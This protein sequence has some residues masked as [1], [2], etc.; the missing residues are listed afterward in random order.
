[1]AK[2]KPAPVPVAGSIVPVVIFGVEVVF[3]ADWPS[4]LQG[5]LHL[6]RQE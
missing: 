5:S 3:R 6:R 4:F 1:M 2:P